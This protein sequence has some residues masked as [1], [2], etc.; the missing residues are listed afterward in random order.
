[1]IDYDQA[2]GIVTARIA[3]FDAPE[4]DA[5]VVYQEHTIERPFGWVFFWG[6]DMYAKTGDFSYAVG[7]NAP[8]IVNRHTGAVVETGTG[9]PTEFYIE[10]YEARGSDP[11]AVEVCGWRIGAEKVAAVKAIREHSSLGLADAK[12]AIDSV[13]GGGRARIKTCDSKTALDLAAAL[14]ELNFTVGAPRRSA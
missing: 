1:M 8:Y 2:L 12:H 4:G 7:G 9:L 14:E 11:H 13:L 3:E 6:S 5:W 10:R